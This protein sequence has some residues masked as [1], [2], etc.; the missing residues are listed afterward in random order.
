MKHFGLAEEVFQ[1][2]STTIEDTFNNGI[3]NLNSKQLSNILKEVEE[4]GV[5]VD[6]IKSRLKY[7]EVDARF[8]QNII[9]FIQDFFQANQ[10]F[11]VGNLDIK[12]K[13]VQVASKDNFNS[14]INQGWTGDWDLNPDNIVPR[15]V[16]IASMNENGQFPRGCYLNA[17]IT[18]IQAIQYPG[19]IR[20]RIFIANPVI[21]NTGN[22]NVKSIAQ[23]V[24]YIK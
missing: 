13:G 16:Q 14:I 20:Y 22:R 21:V 17:D 19:K 2:E 11:D 23:P 7:Y 1:T 8:H 6:N 4:N 18:D 24:R 3:G 9:Q 15:R 5:N 10:P 12:F